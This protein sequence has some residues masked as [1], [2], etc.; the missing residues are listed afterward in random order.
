MPNMTP[1]QRALWTKIQ[2]FLLD[3]PGSAYTFSDRLASENGWS[4][5]FALRA[6]EE[7]KRFMFL[8]CISPYPQTPSDQIDQ[9][10]HLHLLYTESYWVDFC[11]NTLGKRI[12]HGPTKGGP[13]ERQQ[14]KDWYALTM[15][16][17]AEVFQQAPPPDLWPDNQQRFSDIH[18][19]RVNKRQHWIIKKPK[20]LW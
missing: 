8:I 15:A 11:E 9:V 14:Y 20:F 12:N 5:E 4:Y 19:Q 1:T 18:F 2:A 10:W 13:T 6:I 7:Y 17:Y 3:D 16:L